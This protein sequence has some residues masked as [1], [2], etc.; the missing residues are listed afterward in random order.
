MKIPKTIQVVGTPYQIWIVPS[1]VERKLAGEIDGTSDRIK[2]SPSQ[3]DSDKLCT[4][5]HEVLHSINQKFGCGLSE[6]QIEGID[7]GLVQFIMQLVPGADIDWSD[8]P[9]EKPKATIDL[10]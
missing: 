5:A 6:Q 8:I 3:S 10:E 4:L 7:D 2:L 1:L 9:I